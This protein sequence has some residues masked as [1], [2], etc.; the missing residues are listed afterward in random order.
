MELINIESERKKEKIEREK[1]EGERA[2]PIYIERGKEE[3]EFD[4]G[5]KCERGRERERERKEEI[6]G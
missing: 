3:R 5:R 6:V 4:R 1:K 2:H